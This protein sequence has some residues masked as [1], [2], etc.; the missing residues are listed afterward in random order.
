MPSKC[1]TIL[2]GVTA[3]V[4]ILQICWSFRITRIILDDYD[5]FV[6]HNSPR[7]Q[8]Q[9]Q[10]AIAENT[11]QK[12]SSCLSLDFDNEMDQLL[13]KYK[14]VF[15]LM[16]AK[17]A[18]TTYQAFV[19]GC[20]DFPFANPFNHPELKDK[21]LK[22]QLQ[23]PPVIYSHIGEKNF[24]K[25]LKHVTSDTLIIYSHRENTDRLLSGI[26]EVFDKMCYQFW[27]NTK[28]KTGFSRREK[29]CHVEEMNL[30]ENIRKGHNEIGTRSSNN[31]NSE[32][33][34]IIRENAPNIVMVHFKQ[35]NKM[36]QLLAKHHCPKLNQ[37]F[38]SNNS[39]DKKGVMIELQGNKTVSIDKWVKA[40]RNILELVTNRKAGVTSQAT[41]RYMEDELFACPDEAIRFSGSLDHGNSFFPLKPKESQSDESQCLSLDANGGDMDNLLQKYKQVFLIIPTEAASTA[42]KDFTKTCMAAAGTPAFSLVDNFL[43]QKGNAKYEIFTKQ[44]ELPSLVT[45]QLDNA[46]QIKKLAI[47]ATIDTLIIY[48]HREETDR[49]MSAI[50]LVVSRFCRSGIMD[51][52]EGVE[53]NGNICQVAE[54]KLLETIQNKVDE[55]RYGSGE[56]LLKCKTF[57]SIKDYAPNLAFVHYK[58]AM[59]IQKLLSKHHCPES[60]LPDF[61]SNVVGAAEKMSVSIVLEE[62]KTTVPM[63]EWL[64]AKSNILELVLQLKQDVSC[65]GTVR[66]IEDNLFACPDEALQISGLSHENQRIRLSI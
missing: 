50:Q 55:I 11:N 43:A 22:H 25:V 30:L 15:V 6:S 7:E 10:V 44:L 61:E 63:K 16:P 29:I 17:A 27:K 41:T 2:L 32:T 26:K 38:H 53:M 20:L 8:Q 33:F 13:Q 9:Q 23:M 58:Q 18:G 1:K 66:N 40:K 19:Q 62:S 28:T 52:E 34:D 45:F 64:E 51:K 14:Q 31:L 59:K 12:K 3:V 49:L 65:Q 54:N 60:K 21:Y 24:P 4:A 46:E 57:E 47:D 36:I 48:S 56:S 42:Y 37:N 5:G 35:T 39:E